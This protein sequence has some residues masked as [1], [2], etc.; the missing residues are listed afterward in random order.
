MKRLI[1]RIY[2]K[3]T[4][5]KK[6]L[7]RFFENCGDEVYWEHA[8]T[9]GD[10]FC[11]YLYSMGLKEDYAVDAYLKMCS[12]I[13]NEQIKFLKTGKYSCTSIS[14]AYE[15]VY[16]KEDVMRPYMVGVALSQF[17]WENHYKIYT[18]FLDIVKRTENQNIEDY[19]EIGAGHGLFMAAA[20]ENLKAQNYRVVDLSPISINICKNILGYLIDGNQVMPEFTEMNALDF[21]E[22][23]KFDFITMGE[24]IEHVED[25]RP[26]LKNIARLLK[27]NGKAFL[28]TCANSPC[29]D[30]IYLFNNVEEIRDLFKECGLQIVEELVLP[31]EKNENSVIDN[32]LLGTSYAAVVKRLDQ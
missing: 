5:Q 24:V 18:F 19:L 23:V 2:A 22:D 13:L 15:S 17:L 8:N 7:E 12:D 10:R 25:P 16:S 29:I 1:D 9:F 27:P 3:S 26:L 30:H 11:K 6:K 14:D 32:K 4:L 28:T 31:I 20:I 21:K